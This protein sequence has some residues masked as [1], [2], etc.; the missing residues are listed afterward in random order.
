MKI[1]RMLI[2]KEKKTTSTS[3]EYLTNTLIS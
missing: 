2:R 1:K 3:E